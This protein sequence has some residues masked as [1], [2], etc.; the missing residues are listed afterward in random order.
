MPDQDLDQRI[1]ALMAVVADSAPTAPPF[2]EL[3]HRISRPA[4]QSRRRALPV[5]ALAA[6]VVVIAA[7]ALWTSRSN[8]STVNTA[9]APSARFI[10]ASL[11]PG[12]QITQARD[13]SPSR[14]YLGAPMWLYG[15]SASDPA[16]ADLAVVVARWSSSNRGGFVYPNLPSVTFGGKTF[17]VRPVGGANLTLVGWSPTP[18]VDIYLLS[19][20][21]PVTELETIGLHTTVANGA[22]VLTSPSLLPAGDHVIATGDSTYLLFGIVSQG[23]TSVAYHAPSGTREGIDIVTSL[24]HLDPALVQFWLS[25]QTT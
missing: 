13:L 22:P 4:G 19:D 6:A 25:K 24:G 11:P 8:R 17:T 23:G 5:V 12:L 10:P 1:A 15:R 7:V 16:S 18:T 9:G 2:D 14:Y 20:K 3:P 21:L